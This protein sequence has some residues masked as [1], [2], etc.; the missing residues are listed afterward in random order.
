[1]SGNGYLIGSMFGISPVTA[2]AGVMI[3][4]HLVG[5]FTLAKNSAEAWTVGALL[6]WDNSAKNVTT[7]VGSNTKIGVAVAAAANPSSVGNVRLN[8]VFGA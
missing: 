3:A 1:M 7:T 8:A 6:Y 5:V 2:V 4:L